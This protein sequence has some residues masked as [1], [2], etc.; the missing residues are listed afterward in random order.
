MGEFL[1][2]LFNQ[3]PSSFYFLIAFSILWG[4]G[5]IWV[6]VFIIRYLLKKKKAKKILYTLH[7]QPVNNDVKA[8]ETI[9][10]ILLATVCE[11]FAERVETNPR[12]KLLDIRLKGKKIHIAY[13]IPKSEYIKLP[14]A[15]GI[16]ERI[17]VIGRKMTLKNI[18][19]RTGDFYSFYATTVDTDIIRAYKPRRRI[20]SVSGWLLCFS[21][22]TGFASNIVINRKFTGY[23]KMFMNFTLKIGNVQATQLP[24]LLP[25]FTDT[26]D[27]NILQKNQNEINLSK[28]LQKIILEFKDF[29]PEQIKLYL[30]PQGV[31]IRGEI[32][33]TPLEMKNITILCKQLCSI[34]NTQK[35]Q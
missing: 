17:Q 9:K 25:E 16:R 32:A 21:A 34:Q 26:F 20:E 30:A 33:I 12:K 18:I 4:G 14:R 28:K 6:A 29:I 24:N 23:R 19:Y 35:H 1:S 27:I 13:N 10:N 3:N 2:N 31:W 11:K 8:L 15:V 7:Y 22:A 5:L